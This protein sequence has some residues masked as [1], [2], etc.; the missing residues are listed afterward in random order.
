VILGEIVG[1]IFL[2]WQFLS[3]FLFGFMGQAASEKTGLL[4]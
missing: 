4:P 3:V 2:V 1:L